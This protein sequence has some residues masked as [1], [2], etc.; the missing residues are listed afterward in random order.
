MF[1]WYRTSVI[2]DNILMYERLFNFNL[3]D[4]I[5]RFGMLSA[6]EYRIL[7]WDGIRN[8]VLNVLIVI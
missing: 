7:L 6:K 3:I 4:K 8:F 5:E 2:F 1:D